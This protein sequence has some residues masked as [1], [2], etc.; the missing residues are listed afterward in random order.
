MTASRNLT[1]ANEL[2]KLQENPQPIVSA[3]SMILVIM[4]SWLLT[5]FVSAEITMAIT[6]LFSTIF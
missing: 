5:T 6:V 2:W 3:Q 1:E 4:F